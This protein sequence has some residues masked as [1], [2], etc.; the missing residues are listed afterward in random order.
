MRT[1]TETRGEHRVNKEM[2]EGDSGITKLRWDTKVR[3]SKV[4]R[5]IKLEHPLNTVVW[6]LVT[7][8]MNLKVL[9]ERI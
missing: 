1:I 7:T 2:P 4:L 6:S 5:Y 3:P 8:M 9:S